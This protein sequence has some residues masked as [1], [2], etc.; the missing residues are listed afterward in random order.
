MK[1][2]KSSRVGQCAEVLNSSDK[3]KT[4]IVALI[5]TFL[6][7]LDLIGIGV[8]GLLGA[9]TITGVQSKP[10]SGNIERV[11]NLIQL[12]G[13]EFQ[14]QV[15][16]LSVIATLVLMGKT[17][18]SAYLVRKT[19]FFLSRRSATITSD[20]IRKLFSSSILTIREKTSQNLFMVNRLLLERS[21]K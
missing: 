2:W 10:P 11:L 14:S 21:V 1:T 15:V 5:Q 12:D 17:I 13:F 18:A 20:L 16:I 9:I 8:I 3:R 6:G 4:S 19:L 7:I